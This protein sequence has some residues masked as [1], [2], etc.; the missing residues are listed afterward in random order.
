MQLSPMG[1]D[2]ETEA[3]GRQAVWLGLASGLHTLA[4]SAPPAPP[5]FRDAG[6]QAT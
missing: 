5:G 3:P 6:S 4:L 2:V 1:A